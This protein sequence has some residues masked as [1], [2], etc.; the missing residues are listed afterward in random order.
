MIERK[1]IESTI[2][3]TFADKFDEIVIN[4]SQ[5]LS[6]TKREMVEELNCANFLAAYNLSRVLKRL[7]IFT[8]NKLYRTDP[9][10]LVRSKGIGETAI[11]VAMCILDA[12]EYD[13]KK[14]WGWKETNTVKFSAFKHRATRRIAKKGKHEV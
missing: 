8:V 14:W 11:Y 5:E 13:V 3:K 2:S 10:S 4:V 1:T 6:F 7:E 12:N 9:F